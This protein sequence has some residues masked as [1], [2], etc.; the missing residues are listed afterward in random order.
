MDMNTTLLALAS[1]AR[2]A[3]V[4]VCDVLDALNTTT[5]LGFTSIIKGNP[6]VVTRNAK[7]LCSTNDIYVV[8]DKFLAIGNPCYV[9]ATG[10]LN[11]W[12]NTIAVAKASRAI[13]IE[14]L[15]DDA[16]KNVIYR[17]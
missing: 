3:S 7:V 1:D 13:L 15:G 4:P 12:K 17:D 10:R 14:T 6:I 9:G 5:D 16:I 2:L 8:D 11:V